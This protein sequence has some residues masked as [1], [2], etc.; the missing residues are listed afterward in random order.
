MIHPRFS[1][2]NLQTSVQSTDYADYTD[3]QRD[4][5]E[6]CVTQKVGR[7]T[8]VTRYLICENLRNLRTTEFLRFNNFLQHLKLQSGDLG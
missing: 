4:N 2:F 7:K 1:L 5:S 3:F 8:K 6:Q